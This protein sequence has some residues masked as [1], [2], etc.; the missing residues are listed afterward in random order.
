MARHGEGSIIKQPNGTY[1][2]Y[3]SDAFGK[4]HSKRGF[5]SKAQAVE[6]LAIKRIQRAPASMPVTFAQYWQGVIYPSTKDL[7]PKTR[8]EYDRIWRVILRPL[9]GTQTIQTTTHAQV[10]A[11]ISTINA[12]SMQ[13]HALAILRKIIKQA[14]RDELCNS[15]ICTAIK[16]RKVTRKPR[17]IM[18]ISMLPAWFEMLRGFRHEAR[19]LAMLGC[20]LSVSEAYALEPQSVQAIDEAHTAL[21]VE[22]DLV[23]VGGRGV[24]NDTPKTEFRQRTVILGEPFNSRFAHCLPFAKVTSPTS[25][26]YS[27]SAW[28]RANNWQPANAPSDMRPIFATWCSE[29]GVS[30]SLCARA[31]GH[32]GNTTTARYYQRA[33]IRNMCLVADA[34]SAYFMDIC[35]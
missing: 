28:Q 11:W 5:S 8:H 13:R 9:C 6:F 1:R 33:T 32:A 3:W 31:M 30:D 20:G 19:M 10:Q 16:C 29:A 12:P 23:D 25:A 2:A 15:D 14:A 27:W 34:L 26:T 18:D 24:L 35:G 21:R 22:R 17:E 4:Q 7:K